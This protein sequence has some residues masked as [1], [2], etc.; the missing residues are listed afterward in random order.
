MHSPFH[1]LSGYSPNR[2]DV[3]TKNSGKPQRR[4][5]P[6][7]GGNILILC[8]TKG[9][10]VPRVLDDDECWPTHAKDFEA[11]QG[12]SGALGER[13]EVAHTSTCLPR[14]PLLGH[15]PHLSGRT[16]G[17]HH[18][19]DLLFPG[20]QGSVVVFLLSGC[21]SP[22]YITNTCLLL[23][24]CFANIFSQSACSLPFPFLNNIS[25]QGNVNESHNEIPLHMRMAK[26]K[27]MITSVGEDMKQLELAYS[28]GKK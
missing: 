1:S 28:A 24:I 17:A 5:R 7:W 22:L 4:S 16:P 27:K 6:G 14:P 8:L 18:V 26:I 3:L 19:P 20:K 9:N 13:Q 15:H 2:N 23:G 11:Q 25:H 21:K 10:H 12:E